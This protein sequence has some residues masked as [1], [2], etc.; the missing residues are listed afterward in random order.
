MSLSLI[1]NYGAKDANNT[2]SVKT[3]NIG[4]PPQLWRPIL[5]PSSSNIVVITPISG[6]SNLYIPGNIY[7]GDSIITISD[8]SVKTN[9]EKIDDSDI[10]NI[11]KLEPKKYNL[12]TNKDKTH[13]GFIAQELEQI[14]PE[15]V[16]NGILSTESNEEVSIKSVNY[17][18]MIPLLVNK[19]QKMQ[20][21]I[22]E[23][24]TI[25]QVKYNISTT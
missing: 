13:Y 17:L 2:A 25:L 7:V 22:D 11:M 1:P 23:L 5:L 6:Y 8:I 14:Y 4:F 24:K 21:E 15:L 3:F 12:I 20:K 10:D 9:I 16:T 19:I 18:E